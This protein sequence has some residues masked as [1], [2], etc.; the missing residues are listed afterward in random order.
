MSTGFLN[1]QG[2]AAEK[3]ATRRPFDPAIRLIRLMRLIS[4]HNPY[5][6]GKQPRFDD[7]ASGAASVFV[8]LE[9]R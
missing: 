5:H 8:I 2:L 9:H 4:D 1:V 6:N 3:T 7:S